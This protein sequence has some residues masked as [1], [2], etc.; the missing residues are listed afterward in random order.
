MTY[1][2]P[3]T[4]RSLN[5]R[6]ET[7]ASPNEPTMYVRMVDTSGH[8]YIAIGADITVDEARALKA[9]IEAF[10]TLHTQEGRGRHCTKCDLTV[11]WAPYCTNCGTD[12]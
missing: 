7:S 11:P 5:S 8:K 12:L 10:L 3:N 1:I 9:R 6:I 4:D 2:N